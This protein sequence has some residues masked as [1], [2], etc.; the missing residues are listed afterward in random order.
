MSNIEVEGFFHYGISVSNL[1]RFIDFFSN[2]LK[3][4]LVAKRQITADYITKLVGTPN[5]TAEVVMF[6]FPN[7]GYFELLEWKTSQVPERSVLGSLV[8]IG[9]Q[10]LCIYVREI[11]LIYNHIS[12]FDFV[13]TVSDGI[14]LVTE[15]PN[16]GARVAFVVVDKQLY[17][18]LFQ[19][20]TQ[21]V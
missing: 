17:L 9:S 4:Q 21:S 15:G 7:G 20:P 3:L 2:G 10:H 12:T 16:T 5:V 1:E 6:E 11:D 14:V 13:D 18:E 8:G 19:K